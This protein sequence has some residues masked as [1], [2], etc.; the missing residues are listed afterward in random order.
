MDQ[1]EQFGDFAVFPVQVLTI[2]LPDALQVRRRPHTVHVA[3]QKTFF[4]LVRLHITH[5]SDEVAGKM[6]VA[7]LFG[8]FVEQL[9][10]FPNGFDAGVFV[11]VDSA[12]SDDQRAARVA[13]KFADYS[14]H[15][16]TNRRFIMVCAT[17]INRRS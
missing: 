12:K 4:D 16:S 8:C 3:I 7:L 9:E 11:T 1:S 2:G 13:C 6:E 5:Y 15:A 14:V 17:I 10:Y